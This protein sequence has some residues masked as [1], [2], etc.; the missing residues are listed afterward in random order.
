MKLR[1]R[2]NSIRLRLNQR[3]TEKLNFD[4]MYEEKTQFPNGSVLSYSL[5]INDK[6][7]EPTAEFDGKSIK[8]HIPREAAQK[9]LRNPDEIGIYSDNQSL[10]IIIEKDFRCLVPRGEEDLDAY[11]HPKENQDQC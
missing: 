3:E 9:W 2:G 5:L 4:G 11:P 6:V 7:L 10:K 8:V 1:I